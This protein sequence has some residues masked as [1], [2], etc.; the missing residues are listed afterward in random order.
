MIEQYIDICLTD[1]H[2]ERV[3]V[4]FFYSHEDGY[5]VRTVIAEDGYEHEWDSLDDALK[6][7]VYDGLEDNRDADRDFPQMSGEACLKLYK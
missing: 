3:L 7:Q 4:R 5:D 1:E 2:D 6:V